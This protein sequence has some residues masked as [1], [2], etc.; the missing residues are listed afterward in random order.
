MPPL[1][2]AANAD[3][4]TAGPTEWLIATVPFSD[5]EISFSATPADDTH[6]RH[7]GCAVGDALF[8]A[9]RSTW[10]R[11]DAITYVRLI[12]PARAQN[13]FAILIKGPRAGWRP[14]RDKR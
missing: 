10:W 12:F 8:L 7:L 2:Q 11:G 3:F 6:A 4:G 5:A 9:E 1:P 13:D 14:P